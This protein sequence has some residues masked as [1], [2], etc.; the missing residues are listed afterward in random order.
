M[1][2]TD[3]QLIIISISQTWRYTIGYAWLLFTDHQLLSL[4][5]PFTPQRTGHVLLI[6]CSSGVM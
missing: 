2:V 3:I 5:S 4:G 1:S 6:E